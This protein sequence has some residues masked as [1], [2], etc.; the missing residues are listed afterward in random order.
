MTNIRLLLLTCSISLLAAACGSVTTPEIAQL[1]PTL[2]VSEQILAPGGEVEVSV[3]LRNQG[4]S[5]VLLTGSSSCPPFGFGIVDSSAQPM[6]NPNVLRLCTADARSWRIEP[7]ESQVHT[8]RWDGTVQF[9]AD[10]RTGRIPAG[11]YQLQGIIVGPPS[12]LVTGPPVTIQI[13]DQ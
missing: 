9:L 8:F 12:V 11:S 13:I 4:R 6:V 7:G 2:Q 10:G 5:A 3:T 1:L